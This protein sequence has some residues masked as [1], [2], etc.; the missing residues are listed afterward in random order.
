MEVP[1]IAP[2]PWFSIKQAAEYLDI[3]EPTLYRWMKEGSITFRKVGDSTR[4]LKEDLDNAVQVH[5]SKHETER[6]RATCPVCHHDEL[7]EGHLQSTGKIYFRPKHAKFW[8]LKDSNIE[9]TARM[10]QRCGAVSWYGD[11]EKLNTLVEK[12]RE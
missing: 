1:T 10:C 12:S 9:T 11:V 4:F 6:V 5:W 3:G 2:P 8:T 7:V